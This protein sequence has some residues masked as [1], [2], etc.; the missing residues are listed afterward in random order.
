[1]VKQNDGQ[2]I[3]N[4]K[5]LTFDQGV[6]GKYFDHCHAYLQALGNQG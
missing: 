1:M 2:P 5:N 3:A 4:F 6:L